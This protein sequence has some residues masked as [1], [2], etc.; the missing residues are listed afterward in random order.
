MSAVLLF[1]MDPERGGWRL[2]CAKLTPPNVFWSVEVQSRSCE[3]DSEH[4]VVKKGGVLTP[5]LP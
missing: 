4:Q 2:H 1:V 5:L 3:Y